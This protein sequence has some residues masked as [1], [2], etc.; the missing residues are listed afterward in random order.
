[1]KPLSDK[2]MA[3]RA[4]VKVTAKMEFVLVGQELYHRTLNGWEPYDAYPSEIQE[5][6]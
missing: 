1:M 5:S 3:A 6:A 4:G 2:E